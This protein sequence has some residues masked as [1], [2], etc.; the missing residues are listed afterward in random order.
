MGL[1]RYHSF[2]KVIVKMLFNPV[3]EIVTEMLKKMSKILSPAPGLC[4]I[5]AQCDIKY[6]DSTL[7]SRKDYILNFVK[8]SFD[9]IEAGQYAHPVPS[10][11]LVFFKLTPKFILVLFRDEGKIGNLLLYRGLLET[12]GAILHELSED[13]QSLEDLEKNAN[14]ILKLRHKKGMAAPVAAVS[15]VTGVASSTASKIDTGVPVSQETISAGVETEEG[16]PM[17]LEKYRNKKFNFDEGIILQQCN[18][19]NTIEEVI[20]KSNFSK[21]VVC[22]VIDTYEKK[23]WVVYF[24][25]KAKEVIDREVEELRTVKQEAASKLIEKMEDIVESAVEITAAETNLYPELLEKY[26]NK[27]FSFKEGLVLQLCNGKFN[28][29]EI[30]KKT[31]FA[32]EEVLDIIN[33]FQKKGWLLIHT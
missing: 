27:K 8:E 28:I 24:G 11:L 26:R 5:D 3:Q 6:L 32:E 30:I 29:E 23:G 20:K 16:F 10:T 19:K 1:L 33:N 7:E 15:P 2:R 9:L 31:N 12:Y 18:G 22:E 13:N 21:E 25:R 14:L 17:L 4:L